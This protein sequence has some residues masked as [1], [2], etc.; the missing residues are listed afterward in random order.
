MPKAAA[1]IVLATLNARYIHSSFGL[2]YLRAN[3][4]EMRPRSEIMEFTL[5][6]PTAEI[7]EQLLSRQP[8]IIGLGVYIWNAEPMA[9]L[10]RLLKQVAPE[11]VLVLG[12]PEVSHEWQ[13]QPLVAEADYLI[14]GQADLAFADLCHQLLQGQRPAERIIHAGELSLAE[15][16][17][18]YGEYSDSDLAQ[19]VLYVEASR[20]CPFRCAFCLSA[21]DKTARAFELEPLLAE[22]Q[23]LYERGARQFKFVDR[24]F[25]LKPQLSTAI[26]DFFLKRMQPGLFLHFEVIP[27]HLPEALKQ[28]LSR[29]PAG[30]LQLEIG[31]QSLNPEV[32]Q[33]ISRKQDN[34]ATLENLRWLR[35]HTQAHL[36]TD[37]IIGLPG[38]DSASFGAG[39]DRLLQLQPQEIQVGI[40]KR[41]RGAPINRLSAEFG[42]RFSADPPYEILQSHCIDFAQ[43]Q[44]LKRFARYWD[45]LGNSGR[46]R[47]SLPLLLGQ[48]PFQNLLQF[49]DWLY[50]ETDQTSHIALKRLYQLLWRYLKSTATQP[51]LDM[52]RGS[53]LADYTASGSKGRLELEDAEPSH[54]QQ[55]SANQRQLRHRV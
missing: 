52:L 53:I 5:E 7:A 35:E 25:N 41:L 3:L 46:F 32:Q 1:S 14:T 24:T 17:L 31:V 10:V 50:A 30:S 9:K 45:L 21:L 6:R 43:M 11:V 39:F 16:K 42:L 48:N 18:P 49:S 44:R 36:H 54:S 12:G 19:R 15:L 34:A 20:G 40:L 8:Q 51:D 38:E 26:L 4:G 2:R 33:R 27:D 23:R 29:F 55:R 47:Q 28:R 22:L 13:Q 37:L